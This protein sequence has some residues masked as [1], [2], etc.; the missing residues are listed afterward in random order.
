M[1]TLAVHLFKESFGPFVELLNEHAI[2]YQMRQV[3][4]GAIV[5]TASTLEI[6]YAV[7]NVAMWS[8]LAAVLV[9]FINRRRGR[10]VIITT[11]DGAV[12]HVEGLSQKEIESV[13]EMAQS[14]M[15]IDPNKTGPKEPTL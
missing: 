15:V 5:A 6:A 1:Q 2:S 7:G 13:L 10:K 8:S 12:V 14:L 11:K 9:A 4:S 3:R